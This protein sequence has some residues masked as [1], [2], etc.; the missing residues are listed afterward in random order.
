[1]RVVKVLFLCHLAALLFGVTG[2]LVML[3]HPELWS[4]NPYL[5][6]W[7][8]FGMYAA[9]IGFAVALDLS[10]RLWIPTL[11]AIFLGVVPASLVFFMQPARKFEKTAGGSN[12]IFRRISVMVLQK[13]SWVIARRKVKLVIEGLENVPN[14][15]PVL[16]AARHFHHLYDGCVLM[17]AVP[18]R[19]RIFVALDWV[20]KRWL[21]SFMELACN[22]VDWPIVLRSEQLLVT[23]DQNSKKSSR[24]YSFDEARI[25]IRNAMKDS[26]R[27]LRNGDVLAVFPEAYP[28]I[29]PRNTPRIENNASLPFRQGFARLVEMVEKD[30]HTKVAIVPAG[31][32][33]VQNRR[34]N[35]TL[36]FGQALSREDY[37]DSTHLV[38]DV[39][40]RV[41]ELSDERIGSVSMLTEETIQL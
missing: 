12:S 2:L 7:L 40:M 6:V 22:I 17:K 41:R 9:N 8:P 5:I 39:E 38:Q 31:L 26:I 4:W 19:L 13:G 37:I 29:D 21:R 18:R 1:M 11:M 33:Y 24:A 16:I 28:D 25:Y 35:V 32:T 27:I 3:P 15:G 20:R 34:W 23:T 30:E 14:T 10:A 36:R